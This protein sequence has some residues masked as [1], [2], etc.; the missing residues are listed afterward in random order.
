[1]APKISKFL[2]CS[3]IRYFVLFAILT[4]FIFVLLIV[5]QIVSNLKNF[6]LFILTI[7]EILWFY[8]FVNDLPIFDDFEF[9]KNFGKFL[10]FLNWT[11][12]EIWLFYE[13]VN[14]LTIS[15]D[16]EFSRNLTIFKIVKFRIFFYSFK[17]ETFEI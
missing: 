1:M 2:N 13:F 3:S 5:F 16:L 7:S 10:N 15:N 8:E 17:L 4:I 6:L 11:I 14:N 12:S 9:S